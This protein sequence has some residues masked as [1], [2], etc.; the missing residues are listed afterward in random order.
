MSFLRLSAAL[1]SLSAATGLAAAQQR[2][3]KVDPAQSKVN[4]VLKST[5]HTVEG[6]FKV[7]EGSINFNPAD[8][9]MQGEIAVGSA[10]GDTGNGSRDKKMTKDQMQAGKFTSVTFAPKHFAGTLNPTGDS[11]INVQG[12]FT[13]LGKSHEIM[14]PMQIHQT[15]TALEAKGSFVVP[16]V[17]WG[18]KDPS[19]FVL[20]VDKQ[21]TVNLDLTGTVTP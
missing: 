16:F 20:H 2:T 4:F 19:V 18:M 8:G 15:G 10:T 13:L 5:T 11:D 12:I 21:A 9:S 1:L 7:Q 14:V 6:S 3:L 17:A